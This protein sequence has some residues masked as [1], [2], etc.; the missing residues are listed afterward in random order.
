MSLA[1]ESRSGARIDGLEAWSVLAPPASAEHWREGRS[2]MELARAWTTGSGAA[3]LAALLDRHP[4]ISGFVPTR[5][6]AEAQTAFDSYRGGRRNHD[7]LV[8]GKTAGGS[9]VVA[10]EAKADESFGERVRVYRD[11]AHRRRDAGETTF[12]PERLT[13]L[14]SAVAGRPIDE[15]LL[16]LRYQ[17]FSA[18]A[19]TVAA[20]VDHHASQAV[21]V[22]HEFATPLTT[23]VNRRR[24]A[25]DLAAFIDEIFPGVPGDRSGDAWLVG[26]AHLHGSPRLPA[27]LPLYLGKLVTPTDSSNPD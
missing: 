4:A 5:A 3:D 12:A 13:D 23:A 9:T 10:V 14:V 24:N 27:D 15:Q 16:D 20:A 25:Q 8:I 7:L 22:V 19:G 11:A 21:F 1:T 18:V 17:L 6:V 2:A 26:P